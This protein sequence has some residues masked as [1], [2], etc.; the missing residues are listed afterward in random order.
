MIDNWDE[1]GIAEDNPLLLMDRIRS[2]AA[3]RPLITQAS[4]TSI[5]YKVYACV[6]KDE[7]ISGGGDLVRAEVTCTLSGVVFDTLQT[8]DDRWTRDSIGYNVAIEL[9]P[10]DRPLP[11]WHRAEIRYTPQTGSPYTVTWG[12]KTGALAGS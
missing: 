2:Q 5:K 3:N 8:S 6:N 9:Q 11:G 12:I 4:M 10:E 1:R 7:V